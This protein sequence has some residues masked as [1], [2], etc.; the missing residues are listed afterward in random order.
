MHP[1]LPYH[2]VKSY[3]PVGRVSV[4]PFILVTRP[5]L[6]ATSVRE[7]V[8]L[9]RTKPES[10][11]YATSGPG[12]TQHLATEFFAL[13]NG[14]KLLHVPFKGNAPA[15]LAV[16]AGQVDMLLT[17]A[18]ALPQVRSGKLKALA[19]TTAEPSQVVPGVPT[20]AQ[21]G[22]AGYVV[23]AVQGIMA[24]AGTPRDIV[25]RINSTLNAALATEDVKKGLLAQGAEAA[26]ST[27]EEYGELLA[28]E[29]QRYSQLIKQVGVKVD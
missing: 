15:L 6:Q 14:I 10:L 8:D 20:M 17:D 13:H 25:M 28:S 21:S 5:E 18:S 19:V 11:S 9:A 26:P 29:M 12:T 24:P 4:F 23:P 22:I 1:N 27:P 7:L 3:S 16:M 2:G